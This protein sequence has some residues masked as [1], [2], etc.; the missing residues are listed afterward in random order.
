[1]I[2]KMF[3][4]D[5]LFCTVDITN[6][7]TNIPLDEGNASAIKALDKVKNSR[8][9]TEIPNMT[10]LAELLDIVTQTNVFEFD[11]EFYI[12]TRGVSMGNIMAPSY[13]N[14]FMVDLEKRLLHMEED[15]I[16][17]WICCIDD[18][19]VIW[20]RDQIQ[21]Q[22]FLERFNKTHRTMK[23]TGEC[24]PNEAHFLDITLYQGTHFADKHKH[25]TNKH[26]KRMS[27]VLPSTLK[28][29]GRALP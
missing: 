11:G 3:D 27:T 13:N 19:F 15:K 14:I 25:K 22:N 5:I 10:V 26:T 24:S 1:M 16:K 12:Q 7:Y 28:V 21:F 6:M 4:K 23:F 17:L 18:I 9:L 29:L 20:Q 8:H 2:Y